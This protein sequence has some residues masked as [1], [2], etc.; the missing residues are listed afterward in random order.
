MSIVTQKKIKYIPII[1]FIIMFIWMNKYFQY[2]TKITSYLRTLLKMFGG[3]LL[4]HIPR[5]I[6]FYLGTPDIILSVLLWISIY[7][8]FFW[9]AH[10]AIKDEERLIAENEP[11]N[12]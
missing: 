11:T 12:C 10:V 8:S 7:F 3:L 1:N 9:I 2:K 4:M 6:L 5:M